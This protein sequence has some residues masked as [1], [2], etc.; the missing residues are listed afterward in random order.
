MD[1]PLATH[2][3]SHSEEDNDAMEGRMQAWPIATTNASALK[4]VHEFVKYQVSEHRTGDEMSE[5][6]H[7]H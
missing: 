5:H 6:S 2:D 3:S 1:K 7:K 4:S